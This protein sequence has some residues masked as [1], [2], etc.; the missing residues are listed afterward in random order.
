MLGAKVSPTLP[1]M[2]PPAGCRRFF[3]LSYPP[4]E[5]SRLWLWKRV[6]QWWELLAPPPLGGLDRRSGRASSSFFPAFPVSSG[7]RRAGPRVGKSWPAAFPRFRFRAWMV[8]EETTTGSVMLFFLVPRRRSHFGSL[9]FLPRL[10][11]PPDTALLLERF[12][13]LYRLRP[14]GLVSEVPPLLIVVIEA[15]LKNRLPS[16]LFFEPALFFS[17]PL[18]TPRWESSLRLNDPSFFCPLNS[19]YLRS[20]PFLLR[21]K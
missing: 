13:R 10:E 1:S 11:F 18:G 7:N 8:K 15:F 9:F 21:E 3:W 20:A 4:E 19:F 5:F 14:P 2:R 16:S 17:L 12:P 6:Y